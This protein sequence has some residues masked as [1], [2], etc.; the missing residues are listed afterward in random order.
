MLEPFWYHHVS[1]VVTVKC[2]SK[3][4]EVVRTKIL[5]MCSWGFLEAATAVW[6]ELEAKFSQNFIYPEYYSNLVA[7]WNARGPFH[8]T[9][10][11]WFIGK[12]G[13]LPYN[14]CS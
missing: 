14:F 11:V 8:Q 1:V 7:G 10:S 9:K 6:F 5:A 4:D 12:V 2:W 13:G 3:F